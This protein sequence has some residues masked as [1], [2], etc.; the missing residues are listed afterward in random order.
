MDRRPFKLFNN[1][2]GLSDLTRSVGRTGGR[3]NGLLQRGLAENETC[4]KRMLSF[5][6]GELVQAASGSEGDSF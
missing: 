5:T 6:G 3:P 4:S 2:G 1:A